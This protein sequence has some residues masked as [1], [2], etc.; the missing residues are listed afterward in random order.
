MQYAGV[1]IVH[2]IPAAR[3]R[4]DR[5]TDHYGRYDDYD[6]DVPD[7]EDT[8]MASLGTDVATRQNLVNASDES[9]GVNLRFDPNHSLVHSLATVQPAS[10]G[11]GIGT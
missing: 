5:D 2:I 7:E 4:P 10:T 11:A 3:L 6:Y 8:E 1:I 9:V